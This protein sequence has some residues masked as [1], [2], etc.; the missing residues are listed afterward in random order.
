MLRSFS[1]T[2]VPPRLRVR[3]RPHGVARVALALRHESSRKLQTFVGKEIEPG[4][5]MQA[6]MR[7]PNSLCLGAAHS[8]NNGP[9]RNLQMQKILHH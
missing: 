1:F 4:K 3:Y 7:L 9:T 8:S 5:G 2:E 6:D